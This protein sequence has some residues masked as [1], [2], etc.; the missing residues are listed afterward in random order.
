MSIFEIRQ[1]DVSGKEVRELLNLHLGSMREDSPPGL[2]FAL[3]L[4]GLKAPGVTVWSAWDG[5]T[6]AGIAALKQLDNHTGELKSMRTASTHLRR[7]VAAALL[8]YIINVAQE[9]GLRRLSLETGTGPAFEAALSLYR[10]RGFAQG[11]AFADYL[12]SEFNQFLHL[13]LR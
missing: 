6:L 12:G 8:E 3:D 10:S 4:S 1:D 7:G 2:S 9:R 11:P 5:A 13:E